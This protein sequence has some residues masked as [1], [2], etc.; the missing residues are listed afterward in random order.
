MKKNDHSK[1]QVFSDYFNIWRSKHIE[2]HNGKWITKDSYLTDSL[3][4]D[5]FS[6]HI[7]CGYFLTNVTDIFS[8]DIDV[9]GTYISNEFKK[10]DL[11]DKYSK[12]KNIF[13]TPSLVFQSTDSGGLHVFYKLKEKIPFIIL[14]REI[15]K[16]FENAGID[17]YNSN[18]EIRP[19]PR[20]ALRL[21]CDFKNGGQ[22]ID[23]ISFKYIAVKSVK[24]INFI[25]NYTN[26]A[27]Q[28][29]FNEL[30][31]NTRPKS[32][33]DFWLNHTNKKTMHRNYTITTRLDKYEKQIIFKNG[34]TNIDIEKFCF[35]CWI[36]GLDTNKTYDRLINAFNNANIKRDKDTSDNKLLQRV[37]AH[38]K[39]F[40]KLK[41]KKLESY[42][43]QKEKIKN[44]TQLDL[45]IENSIK[46]KATYIVNHYNLARQ[47]LMP[48]VRILKNLYQWKENIRE[49]N[50]ED[51]LI[52]DYTYPHFYKRV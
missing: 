4:L 3:I 45:F 25:N 35:N 43:E 19:T 52:M 33:N 20:N 18:I 40:D 2:H 12:I 26:N 51:C 41:A 9:H 6:G 11:L 42:I 14:E 15:I 21:P 28:Y 7:T 1:T 17:L 48:L 31:W 46:D 27:Q 30:F 10:K 8:F 34:Q 29:S 24:T 47:R 44:G 50:R 49:L 23:P 22:I 36:N 38:F 32:A 16:L 5:H 39:R 37:T 13:G